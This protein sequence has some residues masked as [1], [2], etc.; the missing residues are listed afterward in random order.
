MAV[1]QDRTSKRKKN[2]RRSHHALK[3][4]SL[5]KCG[6]CQ[7]AILLHRVCPKCGH[8]KGK[9]VVQVENY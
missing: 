9:E 2:T 4:P 3:A 5:V 6:N 8:F 1:P 7:E